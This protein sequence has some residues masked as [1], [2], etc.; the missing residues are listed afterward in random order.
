MTLIAMDGSGFYD[1]LLVGSLSGLLSTGAGVSH[2]ALMWRNFVLVL[3]GITAA[4]LLAI[5]LIL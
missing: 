2:A 5:L 3:A 1:P 4:A